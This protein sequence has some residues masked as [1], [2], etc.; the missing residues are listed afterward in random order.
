[1]I[2]RRK[3]ITSKAIEIIRNTPE[4]V[5]YSELLRK[6]HQEFPE[7][8]LNTIQGTIW[9]L[10]SRVPNEI[11][12]PMRGLFR[13]TTFR[14]REISAPEI[15]KE[16]KEQDFY[17]PFADWLKGMGE[18]TNAIS[19]G[20]NRF[21]D[22]WSTPD[23]IGVYKCRESDI[24]KPPTEIVSAEIKTDTKDLITAFGQACSYRLFSHKSYL[25][26]P[27]S[28]LKEDIERIDAL[29]LIFGIGL[30]LFNNDNPNN[31]EFEIRARPIKHEP[32]IFY[33]NKY[34]KIIEKDL[35]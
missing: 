33:A 11:Y 22:K 6:I 8:P 24:V 4:G 34:L 25:L 14:D 21:M 13:Y 15:G 29:C 9:N 10:D 18:C 23:V 31:P 12:K 26:I 3:K 20:G 19:L 16:V 5:R 27:K 17:Q 32:D 2:S 30:V 1:M 28:S 35:L 7:I